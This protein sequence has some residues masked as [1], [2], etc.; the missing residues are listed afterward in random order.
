MLDRWHAD[1]R[2]MIIHWMPEAMADRRLTG[3][4]GDDETWVTIFKC[5]V[6]YFIRRSGD[7]DAGMAIFMSRVSYCIR[8]TRTGNCV[9]KT[10]TVK[11]SEMI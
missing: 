8:R 7:D 6:T 1:G 4:F 10:N 5:H 2:L 11:N 9:A 3:E